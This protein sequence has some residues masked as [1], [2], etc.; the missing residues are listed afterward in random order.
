MSL[1]FVFVLACSL[2]T[3]PAFAQVSQPVFGES[4]FFCQ[5]YFTCES[6]SQCEQP[7][8]NHCQEVVTG[9]LVCVPSPVT[10]FNLVC[11][12]ENS[13]C[14]DA[15]GLEGECRTVQQPTGDDFSVCLWQSQRNFAFC[16][17]N[18]SGVTYDDIAACAGEVPSSFA[19]LAEKLLV[20]DCDGDTVLNRDDLC[21]CE[22]ADDTANG[23]PV[24]PIDDGGVSLDGSV[25][26]DG[27]VSTDA[28]TR[29]DS[30]STSLQ[31]F[32]G[33]GGCEGCA[34]GGGSASNALLAML[35]LATLVLRRRA[36]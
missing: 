23:C 4:N 12:E 5:P 20:G 18:L 9:E 30:G 24:I 33:G 15:D 25:S 28:S 32:G 14:V 6:A 29:P 26:N 22:F 34:A 27:S 7:G 19:T 10:R 8:V 35:V 21:P 36:A 17:D 11:C 1:R 31:G 16:R 3:A 13:D 2:V